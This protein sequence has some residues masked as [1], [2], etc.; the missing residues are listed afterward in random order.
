[1]T[2][3]SRAVIINLE[4]I[5]ILCIMISKSGLHLREGL[6]SEANAACGGGVTQRRPS[7]LFIFVVGRSGVEPEPLSK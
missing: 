7:T 2:F 5:G 3:Q 1:M 4:K 6:P